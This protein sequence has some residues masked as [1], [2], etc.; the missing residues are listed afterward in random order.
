MAQTAHETLGFQRMAEVGSKEYFNRYD[1]TVNPAKAKILGNTKKGDGIRYRG[2]GF[3]QLTGRDNYTRAGKALG[4]PLAEKP[5][6]VSTPKVAA[7]VAVW[8]WK[9]HVR[10]EVKDFKD[11][12]SVTSQVN[13]SMNGL[14]DRDM[15][16]QHYIQRLKGL[17]D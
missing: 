2:R 17:V 6:L 5:Q 13:P 9:T 7:Q 12:I 11:T 4:L 10:D 1:P 8:Y 14:G 3:I 15:N 16:F